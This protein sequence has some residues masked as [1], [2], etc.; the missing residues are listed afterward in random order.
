MA[1]IN[2]TS[3][4][5]S[6]LSDKLSSI[7]PSTRS[8]SP[9]RVNDHSRK[10]KGKGKQQD[11]EDEEDFLKEAYRIHQHLTSLSR[12]ISSVRK[13]Y[14]STIE[15]PPLSRRAHTTH[16]GE[17][18]NEVDEWKRWE[19]V[20]YLTDRERDEIDLRARMIL[21]R[22][23]E[24]VGVLEVGEQARKSKTPSS[25]ISST[26]S[27]VLSFLPSLIPLDASS[28]TSTFQPLINAHRASV[29]WTLNDFLTKLT[30]SV[31]DLQ[32]ERFKR[33]QERMKSLGSN[34][35]IEATQLSKSSRNRKIPDGMVVG[36]D[37]PAFSSV[38]SSDPHLNPTNSQD[39]GIGIIDSSTSTDQ[40]SSEQIQQFESEN[41]ILLENMSTTLS[42]VLSAETSLMEI[43]KLQ[44]ELI[45]HLSSQ[46]EMIDQLYS[47]AI[48]SVGSMDKANEQL[49]KARENNR[50]GRVFLLVFLIGA[51]LGLLFLD[52]YSS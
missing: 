30:S 46:T 3:S 23:K 2:H 52:W 28:S 40:L 24:R 6:I 51:S 12:L 22:C 9:S 39:L 17:D 37:D 36:V 4:F 49:K 19:K 34:A 35:S 50:E 45:Q 32:E 14:L 25:A 41:N 33:K 26:K 15:P 18:G 29:L 20:K 10:G 16:T 5:Q 47:E 11:V 8:K 31:S 21:R 44:N 1:P 13:P 42:S 43:S 27:T 48:D 7:P 38:P